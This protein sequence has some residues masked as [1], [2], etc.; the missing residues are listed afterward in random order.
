[1]PHVRFYVGL[2]HAEDPDGAPVNGKLLAFDKTGVDRIEFLLSPNPGE[3]L[4]PLA[5]IASGGESA[6]LLL[7]LKAILS[8]VDEV[9]TLIFDEVD[10]GVGGR[11][12]QVVGEKLWSISAQHQVVCIT[13][14][15]QVAAFAD[16]HYAIAKQV[17]DNRTRTAIQHLSNEQRAEEIAAM[18][19]GTPVSEHSRRSATEMLDRAQSYKH[20][21]GREV[22]QAAF[23]S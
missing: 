13:H 14:L 17:S 5:R 6:R 12:G 2:E 3:P 4:K 1:M 8:R 11:A 9:P 21:S 15:P 23:I 20:R 16:A 18:L 22:S 19:D 10:V 7:A